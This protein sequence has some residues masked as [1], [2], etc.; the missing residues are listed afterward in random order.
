MRIYENVLKTS[1]NRLPQRAYY[2]PGGKSEYM[3]LNGD[4][5]RFAYFTRDIDYTDNI[6]KWDT[7]TVPSCWQSLGYENPN[8]TNINYPYPYDIP[9]V[10]DDNPCGVYEKDFTIDKLWGKVYYV[11]EGVSSCGFVYVNG[12]YVGFTQGS[13][14][15]AE[16]DITPFV[17]EGKNTLRVKVLKWCCGSYLEDQDFFRFNG[18]FRDTYLLQR[19]EGHLTDAYVEAKDGKVIVSADAEAKVTLYDMEGKEIGSASGKNTEIA[20]ADPVLWNAEKPYLYTVKLEKDGEVIEIETGFRTIEIS[21]TYGLLI[22]GVSVKL[23]GVNHHDTHPTK[24]WCETNEEL[25]K[26]LLLMKE[27]NINCI[28]TSHYPPTPYFLNL[29]NRIGFYVVLETDIE[30]HGVVRRRSNVAYA[31]DVE[32]SDWPCTKPEWK[33]EHVERME[34][35]VYRDRNQPSIIMWSTG[36]ESGHGPNHK[37][38]VAFLRALGDGRLVHVED[39]SRKGEIYS[40]DVYSRMYPSLKNLEEFANDP[41]INMPVFLCEYA[42]A[43]GNGPGDVWDYNEVFD[44]Y[45]KLIG[46]CVWEWAD[47]TVIVD[48]VQKYGGDFKGE[49]TH[50][51]NFCCDGM[52]FSDRSLKAGSLEVKAAYQPMKTSLDGNILTIKNRM[53]F[54]CLCE[55]DFVYAVELD[56][57][58]VC[59]KT[60][61]LAVAPHETEDITVDIPQLTGALG[62]YLTCRL[63]KDGKEVAR[64][65]HELPMKPVAEDMPCGEVAFEEG[66]YDIKI[67]GKNFEYIFSKHYGNFTSMKINGKENLAGKVELTTWRAPTDNER[68]V[69]TYW[70]NNVWQ[71]EGFNRHFSKVY[72]STVD[73][74]HILVNGSLSGISRMPYFN[75][76]LDVTVFGDGTVEYALGGRVRDDVHWL[77]RMG[78]EFKLPAENKEFTYF[79]YGPTESYNDAHHSALMG[80]YTSDADKEYVNYVRPQEHGN[81][82]NTKYLAIGDLEIKGK[83]F[84]SCV[85]NY[86]AYMLDVARHT[87]E[88]ESDGFVHLRVDYKDSG[89]G[90]NSCGPQLEEKYRL[91]EKEIYFEFSISP[92]K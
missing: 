56:G 15:Q 77:P 72:D 74:N 23:H 45:D 31:Y 60:E 76:K 88:L 47:H 22:N 61:K 39:A 13:H 53:D 80:M 21:N 4:D 90:S 29:C 73:G 7:I 89:I 52:V 37:A 42:H 85:S 20:V 65:Q 71:G 44:S 41:K 14:L 32:S 58:T 79:G 75:Y 24:G 6:E 18:I 78:F 64:T 48:G 17:K 67:S 34:R 26:E 84:D 50:D 40:A 59:E 51:G 81:H 63:L 2:I 55:Y 27:L 16:F 8:Y 46:G 91:K 82:F 25:E 9:F 92:A 54:T 35:A 38:M 43:M 57:E 36:N 11:L 70:E 5:W 19:P 49:L 30:T 83:S 28:R 3:L 12:E 68:N 62:A 33:K 86:D 1:E 66:E 10:P 87:D 69:R